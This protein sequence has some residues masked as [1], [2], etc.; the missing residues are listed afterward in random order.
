MYI[1]VYHIC[2]LIA[3]T[4]RTPNAGLVSFHALCSVRRNK[5]NL[6][7]VVCCNESE[8]RGVL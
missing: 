2:L 4:R 6:S 5:K 8:C 3:A 7:V 1:N